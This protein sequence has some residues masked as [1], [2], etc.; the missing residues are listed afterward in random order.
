MK[1]FISLLV[2]MFFVGSAN[3]VPIASG[4]II[5]GTTFNSSNAFQFF[6]DSTAGEQ[7]VSL[8]WD[9][10]PVG[11]FFDTTNASPGNSSSPLTLGSS[12]SVGQIFPNNALLDGLGL[13]TITFSDF[14][15]GEFFRF[16]VDTDFF[17]DPDAF[18]LTGEQFIGA[19]ALAVFSDGSQRIGTYVATDRSGFGSAVSITGTVPLPEPATILLFGLGLAGIGISRKMKTA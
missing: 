16:G 3:A 6:N 11:G 14:D 13:L 5:D 10:S 12:S 8:T 4:L 15:P 19:T 17:S 18:G 7:I 1:K 9:I 2:C